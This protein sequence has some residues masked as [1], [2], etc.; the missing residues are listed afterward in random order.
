MSTPGVAGEGPSGADGAGADVTGADVFGT[1]ALRASTLQ[2]WRS[3]PTRLRE[4]TATETDLVHGGYRDRVLT[5]LAQN[6]ADAASRAGV[7]GELTVR[8]VDG[9]L[10]VA[11]TGAG[12]DTRGVHALSALRASGKTDGVGRFGVGFTAV[13]SLTDA[14]RVLSRTG[15]V[16]FSADRTRAELGVDGPVPV[17]RLVWD[18]DELPPA[19]TDTEVVLPLRVGVDGE[20]LLAVLAG[21]ASELLLE[22]SGLGA[23]T[24]G[25]RR[26]ERTERALVPGLV[27]L[28]V[29]G[30]T[31][32]QRTDGRARWLVELV[33]GE[34]VPSAGDVLRAPTRTDEELSL[35]AVLVADVDLA[36]DRRR[37]LPGAS[38]DGLADGYPLLVAALGPEQRTRLVPRPGFPRSE[39]DE[40]LRIQVLAALAERPWLPGVAG[41]DVRPREAVV[42]DPASPALAWL[43]AEVLP[44]LLVPVFSEPEHAAAL[45]AVG[46]AGVGL[47]AV[48]DA[49]AGLA[50]DPAWWRDLYAALDPLVHDRAALAELAGLPVPLVDGRTV[51]GPRTAVLVDAA[52]AVVPGLR[53]VHP[54]A[55][56][57]LL[58]RLGARELGA[59]ELLADPLLADAVAVLD[60]ADVVAAGELAD[61]VLALVA[62]AGERPGEQPWLGGLL[63]PDDGVDPELRAADE[64]L[65]PGA[66]LAAL[67]AAGAPFATVSA[68]VVARHGADVLRAAGVGWGFTVVVDEDAGGPDHDLD[69]EDAWWRATSPAPH[70]VHAVRDLELVDPAAW[71]Q[72][73]ALLHAEPSTL[74]AVR[75]P[76]GHTAWWLRRHAVVSSSPLGH[77]RAPTATTFEGLL[78]PLPGAAVD[79]A[80]LAGEDVSDPALAELLLERLADPTRHPVAAVVAGTHAALAD[81]L[82]RDALDVEDLDVPERVRAV[83]G[84]VVDA[85]TA[86]VVD[87]PWR[88]QVLP[89]ARLVLG[90]LGAGADALA[91]LLDL[92]LTSDEPHARVVGTGTTVAWAAEP[93]VVLACAQLGVAVPGGGPQRHAELQ[94]ELDG[95]VRTVD[96]WVDGSAV[97]AGPAG[98]LPALLHVVGVRR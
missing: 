78:D 94:V 60:G 37:L 23:I 31:W 3:S 53:V 24:V 87:E 45:A 56:H 80:L 16:A 42:L 36:P 65:L 73:L 95:G 49:V 72:A 15:S 69:D 6:A 54:G 91:E 96:W 89:P 5:E 27:E 90:A 55:A 77:W 17:L 41:P 38:L 10:R 4:D 32:W 22:L 64:L 98:L 11:N 58:A 74:A 76:G 67:L 50:R 2:T 71:P 83:D 93:A 12:L 88:A 7:L 48:A 30:R 1:A 97:H 82:T 75:E 40:A 70:R 59:A 43:L 51:L 62:T 39:V 85:A 46:V 86:L 79:P 13:L 26:F 47:A 25:D 14:P 66:P 29:D 84:S 19:G 20:G 57:P 44:G 92:G 81:A 35:P 52:D 68:D 18:D 61:A 21:R 63:L 34:V 28:Q 8:L 33:H 9:A